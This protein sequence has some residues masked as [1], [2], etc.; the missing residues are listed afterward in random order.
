MWWAILTGA[1]KGLMRALTS[2]E[3]WIPI[4]IIIL[5]NYFFL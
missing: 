1:L 2:Y 5:L 4:I 3:I